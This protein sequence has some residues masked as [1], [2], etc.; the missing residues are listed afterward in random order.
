M[1][2][3]RS[4]P[5]FF[6]VNQQTH[7]LL[8]EYISVPLRTAFLTNLEQCLDLTNTRIDL[9][10]SQIEKLQAALHSVTQWKED[11]KEL[12]A[13]IEG[14]QAKSSESIPD[15]PNDIIWNILRAAAE[16]SK[17]TASM[18][19][20]VSKEVQR[21]VDPLL[22]R[23]ICFVNDETTNTLLPEVFIWFADMGWL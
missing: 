14:I 7:T 18:L 10:T 21:W 8:K 5:R 16:E 1:G 17:T 9:M 15:L 4:G 3:G 2:F 6:S 11:A 20:L 19:S 23:H 13:T 12:A 22:F